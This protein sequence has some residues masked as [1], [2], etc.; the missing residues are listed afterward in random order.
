MTILPLIVAW[1]IIFSQ[2][3]NK[4]SLFRDLP[5]KSYLSYQQIKG[6]S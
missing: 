5:Q 6:R 2:I 1:V 3:F 4:K